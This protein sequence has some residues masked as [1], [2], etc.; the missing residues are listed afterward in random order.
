MTSLILGS[1]I[2]TM[3]MTPFYLFF[4][5]LVVYLLKSEIKKKSVTSF[6]YGFTFIFIL[7]PTLYSYISIT[8]TDKRTDYNGKEISQ[9]IESKWDKNFSNEIK[10]VI[11]DEWYAG[12]LS[13]HLPSRP[14]WFLDL[15][16]KTNELDPDGGIVYA[17]NPNILKQICQGD[18]EKIEK[19][20]YCMIGSK[21]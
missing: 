2:R 20:G 16:N 6:L 1:K 15:K 14:I 13:Y 5:T 21:N 4:G 10:Y 3:W 8:Q 19:Q 11:G 17:G 18:F 7:S 12:N 9:L